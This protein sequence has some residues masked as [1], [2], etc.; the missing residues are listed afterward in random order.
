[1]SQGPNSWRPI[2]GPST[3]YSLLERPGCFLVTCQ[4]SGAPWRPVSKS[5][6]YQGPGPPRSLAFFRVLPWHRGP[7]KGPIWGPFTPGACHTAQ[8]LPAGTVPGSHAPGRGVSGPRRAHR[9]VP[10]PRPSLLLGSQSSL[11]GVSPSPDLPMA[12]PRV[13]TSQLAPPRSRPSRDPAQ[14][15]GLASL[16]VPASSVTRPGL[17]PPGPPHGGRSSVTCL[18]VQRSLALPAGSRVGLQR[19]GLGPGTPTPR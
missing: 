3:P 11:V 8:A 18:R 10:G 6:S 16:R 7:P 1:M 13:Q 15:W 4:E 9:A 2:L 19:P 17:G 5:S 14:P 12:C